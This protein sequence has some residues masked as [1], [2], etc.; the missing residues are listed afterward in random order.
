MKNFFN[1]SGLSSTAPDVLSGNGRVFYLQ[2]AGRGGGFGA[3]AVRYKNSSVVTISQHRKIHLEEGVCSISSS[4]CCMPIRLG[5]GLRNWQ[6]RKH[7][8]EV[9]AAVEPGT[10]TGTVPGRG[11]EEEEEEG[12]ERGKV[13]EKDMVM[14][15]DGS[16]LTGDGSELRKTERL[17]ECAMLAATAGLAFFLSTLLRLEAYLG[18]FF[19][20]PVVISSMRWGAAAGRKTMVATALLLL[21]LSGPLKAA[22]Y[23][24]MHGLVGLSMGAFWRWELNW[25]LS[26]VGC[27]VVRSMGALGFVLL[28]SWLLRENI[29]ALITINAH[30]SVSYMLA[31]L[32]INVVPTMPMIYL[33][34]ASLLF[35][36]CGSFV[37][38]LHVLYAI[39]LR[40]LGMKTS[41][42]VPSWIERAM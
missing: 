16:L 6:R 36:N 9:G 38:L 25:G 1:L 24:L 7:Q 34:F 32:G 8:V 5:G 2:Q 31:A 35:I 18:C 3:K 12:G 28:T 14:D 21:I 29:L 17:V 41:T 37:F 40:R 19:P 22:S 42:S 10:P 15:T 23:L 11:N 13:E 33:V 26:I 4:C 27:T 20:L 39:F 30:A